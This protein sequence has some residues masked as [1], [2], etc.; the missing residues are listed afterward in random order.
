MCVRLPCGRGV[1]WETAVMAAQV[2][3]LYND[4]SLLYDELHKLYPEVAESD[5]VTLM[6]EVCN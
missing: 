2:Q 5:I 3:T 4:S 1:R 6:R